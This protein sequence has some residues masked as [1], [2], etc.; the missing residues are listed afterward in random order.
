MVLAGLIAFEAVAGPALPLW[1]LTIQLPAIPFLLGLLALVVFCTA[2]GLSRHDCVGHGGGLARTPGPAAGRGGCAP[3]VRGHATRGFP[4]GVLCRRHLRA[5]PDGEPDPVSDPLA[6][7]PVRF[8]A[9][10]YGSIAMFGYQWDGRFTKQANIAFFPA[11]PALMQP[12]G[13]MIGSRAPGVTREG[14]MLRILWAGV[15]ISLASFFVAL[16]Y[17]RG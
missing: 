4:R 3:G 7:L 13:Q 6:N 9:G 14:E 5:G 10:W 11:L 15:F 8:D 1:K 17:C 2:P 12:V 16:I